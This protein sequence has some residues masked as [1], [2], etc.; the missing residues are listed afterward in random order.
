MARL[1]DAVHAEGG[2]IA[3]QVT[4]G[5]GQPVTCAVNP[6]A[7]YEEERIISP[8]TDS[9]R[10]AIIGG[11]PAGLEAAWVA[12]LEGHKVDLYE[13]SDHLG[14][15]LYPAATPDFKREL[16]AM[17]D[18]WT[19]ELKPLPVTIHTA[20]P[21]RGDEEFLAHAEAIIIA[22]G[23]QQLKPADIAGI[24]GPNV[25]DVLE[26]HR[27]RQ[28]GQRVVFIGGGLS[29]CD[30]ALEVARHGHEVTIV[31]MT[32]QIAQDMVM[33][34][35]ITLVRGL[36][37]AGVTVL[38]GHEV[39]AITDNAVKANT[40]SGPVSILADSVVVALG[41]QAERAVGEV[42]A[43]KFGDKVTFVGDCVVPGKAGDAITAGFLTAWAL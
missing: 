26:F 38:T 41:G 8:T 15:V 27:G 29:G 32:D 4:P 19:A 2:L 22:T 33:V 9:K 21:V 34:N 37:E 11:G 12:G 39:T 40:A 1:A 23:S 35:K 18:W 42:I 31:E 7:G 6:Q 28:L 5:S 16:R 30:A 43:A 3:G 20:M 36:E 17:I 10:V 13:A 25:C 24:D 14:G